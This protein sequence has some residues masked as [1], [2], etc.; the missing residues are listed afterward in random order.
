DAASACECERSSEVSLAQALHLLNS[1]EI[2]A[3]VSGQRSAQLAADKRPHAERL[4]E[5]YLIALS[6]EPTPQELETLLA[7]LERKQDNVRAAYEDIV[8]ALMNTKEFLYNH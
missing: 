1:T 3:K 6:R 5:Q 8:W 2:L 7:Y 4:R